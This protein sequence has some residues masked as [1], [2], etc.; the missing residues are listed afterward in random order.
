MEPENPVECATRKFASPGVS[1]GVS[2]TTNAVIDL[3]HH[4][5]N[6]DLGL[7]KAAGIL[8]VIHKATQ[9]SQFKDPLYDSNGAKALEVGLLWGAYHFG[10]GSDGVSQAEFFL[11][12]VTPDASTLLVLD[13]EANPQGPSMNLEEARAFVTRVH[14]ITGTWPGLYAGHYLKDLLGTHTDPVLTNCWL[15][16]SQFGPTPVVPP[17]WPTWTMWQYTDGALGPPPH[18]VTGIGLCDRDIFNGTAT[19]LAAF[20]SRA[21]RAAAA[22]VP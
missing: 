5:G 19:D 15:W 18:E 8:G 17:A 2:M 1:Y 3:S 7:A 4:N 11:N 21:P 14:E 13:F 22:V 9:G 12:A 10:D 6:I 20:W 16:L